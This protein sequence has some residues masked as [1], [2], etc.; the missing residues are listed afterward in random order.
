MFLPP[1]LAQVAAKSFEHPFDLNGNGLFD[2]G[3]LVVIG[4]VIGGIMGFFNF[5]IRIGDRLWANQIAKLDQR[6]QDALPQ[7]RRAPPPPLQ[8]VACGLHHEQIV[9]SLR[10]QSLMLQK[11]A[12]VIRE[13]VHAE[14]VR[15]S[16]VVMR[17][18]LLSQSHAT[19]H[20]NQTDIKRALDDLRP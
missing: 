1:F 20:T 15:T 4:G 17:L 2:W 12:D 16:G 6:K 3:D 5:L 9:V 7:E 8:S 18:E 19:L 14:E 10:E 13:Q 11:L